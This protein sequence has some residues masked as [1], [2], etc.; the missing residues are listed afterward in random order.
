MLRDVLTCDRRVWL[1]QHESV[2]GQAPAVAYRTALGTR[3]EHDIQEAAEAVSVVSWEDGVRLTA[4]WMRAGVAVIH[5][6]FLELPLNETVT[7]RGRPDRLVRRPD[8]TY[9]PVE[10]KRYGF[11]TDADYLQLDLYCA[12]A[13][14]PRGEFWLGQPVRMVPHRY[15]EPRLHEA[16]RRTLRAVAGDEPPVRIES[17]CKECPWYISCWEIARQSGE[18][19]LVSGLRRDS[20][21]ALYL[22]GIRTVAQLAQLTPDELRQIRGIKS[23]ADSI[24]AGAEALLSGEPVWHG[25]LPPHCTLPGVMF[26]CETD[27]GSGVPWSLGWLEGEAAHVALVGREA[28]DRRISDGTQVHV[29]PDYAAAWECMADSLAGSDAPIFHWTGYDFGVLNNTA[30]TAVKAVLAPRFVDLHRAFSQAVRFP[31]D[32]TSLKRVAAYLGY[33]WRAYESWFAAWEDYRAWLRTGH[34]EA[35]ERSLAY[36]MDDVI[37]LGRVWAWLASER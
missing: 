6:G 3:H 9:L 12:L 4:A 2:A 37:A 26:D 30:P 21:E 11:L 13:G 18:I 27:P 17:H 1:D 19:A 34:D 23:T 24:R 35:L 8:G 31:V 33:Q 5:Q 29:L 20:R 25:E 15:D 14:V 7:L 28:A 32:G 10:I 36:Q 16:I 22:R